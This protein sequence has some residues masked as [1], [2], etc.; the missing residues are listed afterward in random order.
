MFIKE[1]L[2]NCSP[3]ADWYPTSSKTEAAPQPTSSNLIA[4]HDAIWYGMSLW[5]VWASCPGSAPF[6]NLC[7]SQHPWWQGSTR[8]WNVLCSLQ[9]CSATT[10]TSLFYEHCS[11]SKAIT[12]NHT[13]H[14]EEENSVPAG[15]RTAAVR[16]LPVTWCN[17]FPCSTNYHSEEKFILW[18]C[19]SAFS[20]IEINNIFV[21]ILSTV[22]T[23]HW[24]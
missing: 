4:Q 22:H 6:H 23:L 18:S 20:I 13:S 21:L 12:Q 9:N 5:P 19:Q 15:T 24:P 16:E 3:H 2:H 7:L 8:S 14:Y 10:T 11:S 17:S 1:V